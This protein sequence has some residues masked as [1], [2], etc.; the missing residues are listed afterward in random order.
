MKI[1]LHKRTDGIVLWLAV[2]L[3]L[4]FLVFIGTLVYT[5][6][7]AIQRLP[8]RPSAPDEAAIVQQATADELAQLQ[9]AHSNETVT[10]VSATPFYLTV[11]AFLPSFAGVQPDDY[12]VVER[13]TNLV[14]WELMGAVGEGEEYAD[15][16]P[17]PACAF[18]RATAAN[19]AS[20]AP[21]TNAGFYLIN[22]PVP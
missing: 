16:N 11:P 13:S 7:K 22:V 1:R 18:Y 8:K 14:D 12:L 17:P 3:F 6:W 19:G 2:I 10:I 15:T 20:V 9:A 4:L 5:I 21:G